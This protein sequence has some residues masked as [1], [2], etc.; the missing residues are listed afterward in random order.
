[1]DGDKKD[2]EI[3]IPKEEAVFWMD[4]QGRWCNQ[5]GPFEHP[6]IIRYF[7]NA[8]E[9][10]AKGYFVAQITEGA[11]EKVYFRYA[12]TPLF[13]VDIG[14]QNPMVLILNTGRRLA[15]DPNRLFIENDHLYLRAGD[16]QIRFSEQ[17]LVRFA[18][19]IEERDDGLFF[20]RGLHDIKIPEI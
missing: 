12:D 1:M 2:V 4:A 16:E 17:M 6:R 3:I 7:N 20:H 13:V 8:I 19:W 18:N 11:R 10:D 14:E 9:K 15:L 5:H